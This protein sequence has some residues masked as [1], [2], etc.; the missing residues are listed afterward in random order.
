MWILR[1]LCPDCGVATPAEDLESGEHLCPPDALA[2]HQT[3][4]A[5]R[6]LD[7]IESVVAAWAR[8]PWLQKRLAFLRYVDG[9]PG[10]VAGR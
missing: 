3:L 5:L 1:R 6:E 4:L 8:E 10:P 7:E 9:R 2:A